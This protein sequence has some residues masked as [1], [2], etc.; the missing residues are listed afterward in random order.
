MEMTDVLIIGS[1]IAALQLA[2][3]LS[4]D[5]NVKI[6]TKSTIKN[7][8]SYLAQGGIAAAIGFRDDPSKHFVDTLEA[9]RFHNHEE[10]V[11]EIL[12]EAPVLIGDI[13]EVFDKDP[14]GNILL[15]LEGAHSE[16]R[17]VHAGGDATGKNVIEYLISNLTENVKIEENVFAFT[18]IHRF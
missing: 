10:S 2:T 6:L 17:I 15:G 9:G 1:G 4:P 8:N 18:P 14:N 12:N 11:R 5:Q 3:S 16:K 7:A 13:A